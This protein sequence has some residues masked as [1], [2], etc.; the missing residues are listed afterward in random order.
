MGRIKLVVC[1]GPLPKSIVPNADI[2]VITHAEF[3]S[4]ARDGSWLKMIGAYQ[5]AGM[6][7]PHTWLRSRPVLVITM[8]RMFS[9]SSCWLQDS[10]GRSTTI[11]ILLILRRSLALLLDWL[12][13]PFLL[14][15]TRREVHAL[16]LWAHSHTACRLQADGP[17]I[18]LKT[19]LWFSTQVGGSV[20]HM[21][22]VV[23]HLQ[24]FL[25][26]PFVF[27]TA[28]NPLL[29]SDIP[30]K[31][32][33]PEPRYW[34]FRGIPALMF[35]RF[36]YGIIQAELGDLRPSFIYQ[37]YS[38]DNYAAVLLA[39]SLRVPL[40]TEYN[41]S[42]VW[43]SK[44]WGKPAALGKLS[45]QIEMLNLAASDLV[46]VVS[47]VLREE[48]TA[49]GI[50][51]QKILVNP[52]G[53]D[54]DFFNPKIVSADMREMLGL[55]RKTVIGFIGTFGPWHGVEVLIKAFS[56]LM[57]DGSDGRRRLHLL[58]VGDGVGLAES[59]RL[60]RELGVDGNCTFTGL[61]PQVEGP[62]YLACCDILVAPHIP[63]VDGTEFFGSPT[64][65][66]EYMSMGRAIV[67]SRLGQIGDVLE[68]GHTGWLVDPGNPASLADGLSVLLQD[69]HLRTAMGL[70]ARDEAVRQYSWRKHVERIAS[71]LK[72]ICA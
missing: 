33:L 59:R 18:Y 1:D 40:V 27:S 45:G 44:H 4:R 46:V 56:I 23:N 31:Q 11:G 32:I 21:A 64:K 54:T 24:E 53:V 13:I 9:R 17:P 43:I 10:E 5:E 65:L 7:V 38:L 69:A 66:F 71:A 12:K 60:A 8:L 20:T 35:S 30:W 39:R 58:L 6:I 22:G 41:G 61:V 25:G 37:R 55:T 72:A 36:A 62:R 49:R 70:A 15:Q 42:E 2:E 29:S 47:N 3:A 68:H 57:Q 67:A 28:C 51:E 52:N 63:N 19:D 48:L 50:A 34:D 26:R 14:R 16:L